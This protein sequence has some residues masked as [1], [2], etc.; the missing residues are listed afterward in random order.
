MYC[1]LQRTESDTQKVSEEGKESLSRKFQEQFNF[2]TSLEACGVPSHAWR[3]PDRRCAVLAFLTVESDGHW[4]ILALPLPRPDHINHLGSAAH[5][6]MDGL[7]LVCPPSISSYKAD[8]Q[9]V[10][11]GPPAVGT[12]SVTSFTAR[13]FPGSNVRGQS[14]NKALAI[15]GT[16]LNE[17]SS[18]SSR[19]SSFICS[20]SPGLNP[21]GS[22][23]NSASDIFVDSSQ[24]DKAVKRNSRKKARKK[25]KQSRKLSCDSGPTELEILSEECAH[26]S[27]TSETC[28]NN[29]MDHGNGPVS[30]VAPEVSLPNVMVDGNSLEGSS[31]G[32][33]SKKTC[34]SYADEGDVSET[35]A[36]SAVQNYTG[37]HPVCSSDYPYQTKDLS[38]FD[39]GVEDTHCIRISRYDD[40]YSKGL[41]DAHESLALDLVSVA[42]NSDDGIHASHDV[43]QSEK[44]NCRISTEP[45]GF[46]SS[47]GYLSRLSS[48]NDVV[49]TYDPIERNKRGSQGSSCSDIQVVVPGKR[50]KQNKTVSRS[51][52]VYRFG[53]VGRFHDRT[54]KENNHSV[55]QKVQKNDANGCV[56]EL[57]KASPIYSQFD[58][59]LKEAPLLK[60][61]CNVDEALLSK[62]EDK[63]HFKDK[64]SRKLKRKNSS[65]LKQEHGYSRKGS[66]ADKACTN[67]FAKISPQVSN[68]KGLISVS[69]S[70]SQIN[71]HE[72]TCLSNRV[73]YMTSESVHSAHVY[74]DELEPLGSVCGTVSSINSHLIGN[75]EFSLPKSCD[76]LDQS[77]LLEVQSPVY[78]PHLL[79]NEVGPV[80]KETSVAEYRKQNHGNG[81]ILQRWIPIGVKDRGFT[82]AAR[83]DWSSLEHSDVPAAD[84]ENTVEGKMSSNSQNIF[85]SSTA[86]V[87]CMGQN[88][89]DVSS[90]LEDEGHSQKLGNQGAGMLNEHDNKHVAAN[91]FT[92]KSTYQHPL[93]TNS[94]T[95]GRAA[96]DACRVQL[97]SE[98]IQMATGGPIAEFERLLDLS[99]PTVSA[100]SSFTSCQTCLRD[101]DGGV[102]LCRHEIPNVPLGCLWQWYEKHGSYGLEIRAEDFDNS[103]RLGVDGFAFRA[104]FVPFLS[105]VQLFRDC[106]SYPVDTSKDI[107]SFKVPEACKTSET[108]EK[109]S[110]VDHLPIFSVLFPQPRTKDESG[111]QLG[112]QVCGSEQSPASGKDD[113]S[114]QS[115]D[116]KCSSD[117]ELLFEYFESE[118][119]QQRRPLYEKIRELVREGPSHCKAYGDSTKLESINLHDLHP[120]SWYSVAWY[121]IYRIPDGNFRAAFLTYHSLGHMVRRSAKFD[122]SNADACIVSPVVGLQSYN[123]QGE[124]WFQLRQSVLSQTAETPGLNPSVILKERLRTLEETAS[125][126]SRSVVNK[127]NLTSANRHPDY[128]FF[129]SRRR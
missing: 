92:V 13:N 61:T 89:G 111:P 77:N 59:T 124:C 34:S 16:K 22:K 6:N 14:R 96:N 28:G 86:G 39:G 76:S 23:A 48:L 50:G 2:S 108:S 45:P 102:L 5:V 116:M 81:S 126:M 79:V 52:S 97:A 51:S 8:Q 74:L 91:F 26:G 1:A 54:G 112:N 46:N 18:N 121:P 31:N 30:S 101:Q 53:S 69:R 4:R 43:Q 88:S 19:R 58:V 87:M 120:C 122:I 82:S 57:K 17:L 41:S 80:Q 15:K 99:S 105:A 95:I 118:Q 11:K 33:I 106:R 73:G 90:A 103:K 123:A 128:E 115:V 56:G 66:D 68:Q 72:A 75:H 78:I 117:F 104:Y 83:S 42:S 70:H 10:K 25:G 110:N 84:L 55:W 37:G 24:L 67:G 127:G 20:N 27:L 60:R 113:A 21:N 64:A 62:S 119:P 47:K 12:C 65:A 36:P 49:D 107:P 125:L 38:V 129:L 93:E 9:N 71:L 7:N 44:K 85:S 3:N 29:D 98:A 35:I 100:S 94:C 63:K 32:I 40:T 114:V 109:A